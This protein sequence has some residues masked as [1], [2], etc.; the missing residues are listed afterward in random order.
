MGEDV[1]YTEYMAEHIGN[2]SC[3]H[4]K[5]VCVLASLCKVDY[6]SS[7][8]YTGSSLYRGAV[9]WQIL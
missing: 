3:D 7:R 6:S 5:H 2:A 1:E 8:L 4:W 9:V